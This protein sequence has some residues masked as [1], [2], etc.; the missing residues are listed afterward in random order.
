M[1]PAWQEIGKDLHFLEVKQAVLDG[2]EAELGR[3]AAEVPAVR[4]PTPSTL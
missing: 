2:L 1:L 4:S 3:P